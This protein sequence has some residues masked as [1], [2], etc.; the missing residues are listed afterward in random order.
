MV[1]SK[2]T[3]VVHSSGFHTDDV[4]AVATLQLALGDDEFISVVRTR[5]EEIIKNADY[6]AD[7]GGIYDPDTNRFDHHQIGGAGVRE[8]GIPYA[9]FGLVWKKFGEKLTGSI[10]GMEKIDQM[11]VQP[12]DALDNGFKFT[13]T[14]I[15]NLHPFDIDMLV[16]VFYPT[17]KETGVN[18][19]ETFIKLV[20]YAKT[21]M[22]RIIVYTR[23][24]VEAEK[25]VVE[26]Y[27]KTEDKRLI[28]T[29]DSYPWEETL[30][31]FSEPL[32]VIYLNKDNNWS[33]KS[34][35]DDMFS[36]EPRKKL[37]ESWAGK[38]DVELEKVTGVTGAIFCHNARFLAVA[39]TKEAILKMAEI[40]LRS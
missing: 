14:L 22:T 4:F 16:D 34:I 28:E 25:L 19:D 17:W 24:G 39:K 2:K 21:L 5:D 36:F 20:S 18:V 12:I 23:D 13:E 29:E 6:V 3:I 11:I 40:A 15:P 1:E 37:P 38:R 32:F 27:N 30:S 8:N 26:R 10:L 9:A 31:K 35:R 7:V 33:M